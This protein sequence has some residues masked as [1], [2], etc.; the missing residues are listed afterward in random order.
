[1]DGWEAVEGSFGQ[2]ESVLPTGLSHVYYMLLEIGLEQHLSASFPPP[3]FGTLLG[4]AG[5][6]GDTPHSAPQPNMVQPGLETLLQ[7]WK[8]NPGRSNKGVEPA[9]KPKHSPLIYHL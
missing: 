6:V 4:L 9:A 7:A 2:A 5:T 8:K 3:L 1:M